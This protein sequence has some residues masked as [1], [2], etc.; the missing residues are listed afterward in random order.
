MGC[1]T[2]LVGKKAT[3]D[4]STLMARNEDSGAG[5]FTEKR[6]TV[7]LPEQQPK[8]YV[9]VISKVE[10]ELP[11]NPMRYTAMPNALPEEGIWAAAGINAANVAMTATETLTSNA[12]V[13]GGDPLFKGGIGEEDMV[14]ITLPYIHSARE[15]VERL[16]KLIETYGTYEMNGI[17]FQD[18]DELW[19]FESIGGHHW[20][21]K[22]VPDDEY[23]VAPNQQAI[24]FFDFADAYSE[25]KNHL[26]APDLKDFVIRNHLDRSMDETPLLENTQFDCRGAFGSR[27]E[28]DRSYNTPRAWYMLRYLSPNAYDWDGNMPD[29]TPESTNLP[30]SLTPDRKIT[31]ED[32]KT[33]L[34]SYYQGTAFNP[35]AQHGDG[36]QRGM[37][38]PIGINRNNFL[39]VTQLRPYVDA[40]ISGVEWIAMGSNAFNEL[41]AVY[42][43]VNAAPAYLETTEKI[44]STESFYWT[45][46][47]IGALADAHYAQTIATIERYQNSLAEKNHEML[48]RFDAEFKKANPSQ[49]SEFL[50]E[51][52]EEIVSEARKK[53]EKLLSDVLYTASCNMK[54]SFARSDA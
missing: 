34:S 10:I 52:N 43:N 1:T 38:R 32:I 29:F 33:V 41:V 11:E 9:S 39:S 26:C 48:N 17:G 28:A 3:Y 31:V 23:I 18:V 19:W 2:I 36:Q 46:R 37:Y 14:T 54:N 47:I 21:A 50:R 13:L 4:G 35:Y 44:P 16:G 45:N 51:C 24:D 5:H 20:M 49:V 8:K 22:R 42:T 30:F 12:R 6:F 25:K 53:T 27:S 15:G 7:V 40:A